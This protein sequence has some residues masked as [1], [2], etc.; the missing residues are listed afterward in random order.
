MSQKGS[1]RGQRT[2]GRTDG[3]RT[4]EADRGTESAELLLLSVAARGKRRRA[5]ESE[6]N[7]AKS[8][9]QISGTFSIGRLVSLDRGGGSL[10]AEA[11]ATKR[12]APAMSCRCCPPV[13]P[14][15]LSPP[16]EQFAAFSLVLFARPPEGPS[17]LP[18]S[19]PC[20]ASCSSPSITLEA[21]R[22][23]HARKEGKTRGSSGACAL[24][25]SAS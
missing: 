10:S 23:T 25:Y 15:S 21:E 6:Q 18:S 19:P 9:G 22:R 24:A 17:F 5:E 13:P 7:V 14:P 8:D 3:R 20:P 12:R 11:G 1:G 16:H 4:N 2:G